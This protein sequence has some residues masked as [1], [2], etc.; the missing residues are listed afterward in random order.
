M[1]MSATPPPGCTSDIQSRFETDCCTSIWLGGRRCRQSSVCPLPLG[2]CDLFQCAL[3]QS[4]RSSSLRVLDEGTGDAC[5]NAA[6][7]RR[8]LCAFDFPNLAA[9]TGALCNLPTRHDESTPCGSM[10]QQSAPG[11]RGHREAVWTVA[12]SDTAGGGVGGR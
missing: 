4:P 12:R 6:F 8:D 3:P 9:I 11:W 10:A 1:R 7:T 5:G 2:L